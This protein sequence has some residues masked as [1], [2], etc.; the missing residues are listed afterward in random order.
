VTFFRSILLVTGVTAAV[1][2]AIFAGHALSVH[3]L[4]PVYIGLGALAAGAVLLFVYT[5]TGRE[6]GGSTGGH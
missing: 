5:R 3:H 4:G 1:S 6:A 2:F